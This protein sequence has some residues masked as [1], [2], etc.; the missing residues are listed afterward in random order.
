M[1]AEF[2]LI[3][4]FI[5]LA[6]ALLVA[7]V[8]TQEYGQRIG[9]R[10]RPNLEIQSVSSSPV[11]ATKIESS[12][13]VVPRAAR[14]NIGYSY[15]PPTNPLLLPSSSNQEDHQVTIAVVP[16]T[17]EVVQQELEEDSLEIAQEITLPDPE[18]FPVIL[19][20]QNSL[21]PVQQQ[22]PIDEE[23]AFWDFRESIPGEP[24]F[25]YPILDK[26]PSTSFKCAGQ[27]N[28]GYYADVETR[29]Q[30]FHVC[31]NIPDAEPIKASF[32]CPNGTIFNQEVFVCQWWTDVNCATSPQFFDLNKNIGVV[33]ESSSYNAAENQ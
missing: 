4:A 1:Y 8:S 5:I 19:A 16:Q 17:P 9:R 29:C 30:V 23:I 12:V 11:T 27:R 18:T 28:A 13:P 24:E 14:I 2:T 31:T 15:V 7:A 3:S 21:A 25:D 26:I 10:N 32:L 6:I 20:D 33:P 22:K